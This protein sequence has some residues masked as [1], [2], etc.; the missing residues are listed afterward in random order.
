MFKRKAAKIRKIV[1]LVLSVV[2]LA[3]VPMVEVNA[4][5]QN[6]EV[7][8][9]VEIMECQVG[10][11]PD[12]YWDY[13]QK[14]RSV[15]CDCFISVGFS[16]EGLDIEAFTGTNT[17]VPVVGIK[18]IRVEQKVWYGWKLVAFADGAEDTD[19]AGISVHVVF[20]DAIKDQTYRVTCV[21]YA[22]LDYDDEVKYTE[23]T[24]D[25]GAFVFTY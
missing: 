8:D 20:E 16:S 23:G 14:N 25:T 4:A 1:G 12:W 7:T 21:H 11:V 17:V 5:E 9:E 13:L 6:T 15:L 10:E 24:T 22:D 19:T 18:D 2:F 3:S